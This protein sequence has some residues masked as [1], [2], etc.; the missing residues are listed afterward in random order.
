MNR[1]LALL[2]LPP[3][4]F[5]LACGGLGGD[6]MEGIWCGT[7]DKYCYEFRGEVV[8]EDLGPDRRASGTWEIQEEI[9][10]LH[11]TDPPETLTWMIT[12]R[13]KD[14]IYLFDH[15]SDEIFVWNRFDTMP[16]Y[17]TRGR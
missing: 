16:P 13:S 6:D 5:T 3:L 7:D 2:A 9:L 12:K 11:Y 14:A 17:G 10:M 4:A 15:Q 8:T 1:A